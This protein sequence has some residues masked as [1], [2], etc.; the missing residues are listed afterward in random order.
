[1]PGSMLPSPPSPGFGFPGLPA[2]WSMASDIRPWGQVR[3]AP[4]ATP[5]HG[6]MSGGGGGQR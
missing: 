4:Q 2:G 1:M 6:E 3:E 5:G